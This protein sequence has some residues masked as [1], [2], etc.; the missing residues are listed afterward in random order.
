[1]ELCLELQSSLPSRWCLRSVSRPQGCSSAL[2]VFQGVGRYATPRALAVEH[3]C[4]TFAGVCALDDSQS[5]VDACA[6]R[7][8]RA[9]RQSQKSSDPAHDDAIHDACV[10]LAPPA[11]Q[12]RSDPRGLCTAP[13]PKWHDQSELLRWPTDGAR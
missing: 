4:A 2:R 7:A 3:G 12:E 8:W 9:I 6:C 5:G 13:R 10:S 1:M 11:L